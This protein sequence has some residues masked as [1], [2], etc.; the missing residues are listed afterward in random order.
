M[1]TSIESVQAALARWFSE[2][3]HEG[4]FATDAELRVIVWNRWME[5]HTRRPS[6][7]VIGQPLFQLYP[8]MVSRGIDA[9]Y[10]DALRDGRIS[11]MSHALHG[12][13]IPVASTGPDLGLMEMP[14]SGRIAPLS[15]GTAI[16]GTVTV[17]ENVSERLASEAEL[18]RQIEALKVAR[19]TAERALQEKDQFLST[20]SHELRTPLNA[21]LGWTRTLMARPDND[22]ALV[23]R[24]LRV[25]ER[26]AAAQTA[27]I[28]DILDVARIVSGKLR[29]DMAPLDLASIVNATADV[30]APSAA[31]KQI[32]VRTIVDGSVPQVLGDAG[33]LQ[34][35]IGNLLSNAVKFSDA[36]GTIEIV[37]TT[38][39]DVAR[40]VVSD[41][42][43][44]IAPALLPFIFERFRQGDSSSARRHG[45]LGLGLALVRDL[46]GLHGGTIRA[47]SKGEQHGAA[48]TVDF[49][50]L[51]PSTPA[52]A[53]LP[54]VETV[55]DASSLAGML[56]LVVE[57]ETDSRD[58]LVTMLARYGA[59]VVAVRT[60]GAALARLE[61]PGER[62]VDV[63]I[64]DIGLPR[65][66]GYELVRRMRSLAPELARI[67]AIAVTGYATAE[68][69]A[70]ALA[71]GYRAHVAK[72]IS[73]G[74]LAAA[75]QRAV[76]ETSSF[77]S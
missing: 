12:Y 8:D 33:R 75:V 18:R 20:L 71:A 42:G 58:L 16:I 2:L 63:V 10:V 17:V 61:A 76:H 43:Q 9:R 66:D 68:D 55:D 64:S 25:I 6:S 67:P 21:V 7:T 22:P 53:L 77:S 23:T 27:M 38:V 47:E 57:D 30:I 46:V 56:A 19:A 13:I 5:I 26:N 15:D 28:D 51:A 32:V 29:L 54:P 11:T 62:R 73:P 39:D 24:A 65:H 41:T 14:Q 48:F 60:C 52:T 3:S 69:R 70:R 50:I 59:D 35:I 1:S 40:L 37:L 45:G 36:G 31:A 4:L 49:P 34:Q 72:P 74:V 44:G